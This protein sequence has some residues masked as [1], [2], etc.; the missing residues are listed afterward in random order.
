MKEIIITIVYSSLTNVVPSTLSILV[1]LAGAFWIFKVREKTAAEGKIFEL[2]RE[3]ANLLQSKKIIGPIEG[4]SYAYIDKGLHKS[5]EK[6][7]D[8]AIKKM[9]RKYLYFC[10]EEPSEDEEREAANIVVAIATERLHSLVPPKVKWSGQ[11]SFYNPYGEDIEIKDNYFPF[12]TKQYRQWIERFSDIYNDLWAI[13]NSRNSFLNN[14]LKGHKDNQVGIDK[15]FVNGWLDKIGSRIKDI[16]PIHAKLLTQIQ[17][18][19]TQVDLPRLG[20]DLGLLTLY[21]LLLLLSGFFAPKLIY[22]AELMSA[23]NIL[24]L[25]VAT[26][27]SYMLIGIR[28]IS[29]VQPVSEKKP[30]RKIFIPKLFNELDYMKK[31][32]MRY[33]PHVINNILSLDPDLKLS[34]KL[35]KTLSDLVEKIEVFNE[36]ASILYGKVEEIIEPIK[37]EFL[38]SKKNQ[39][40]F[41]I[42]IFEL[43]NE[44]YDLKDIKS[45]ILKEEYNFSFKYEEIHSLRDIFT[46]NLSELDRQKRLKLC[47]KLECLR[48]AIQS[49]PSYKSTIL[50]L[51]DLQKNREI[52]LSQV[53]KSYN[54]ALQRTNR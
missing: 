5:D 3:I 2:G 37:S 27:L 14:F 40:G 38:T 29:A 39:G 31:Q 48:G 46:I 12:G 25:A 1:P 9:L 4:I 11:G 16:H 53:E 43:A 36:F 44:E 41:S 21:G 19:D 6:N 22:L 32:C 13:T 15:D 50:A 34:N 45:R 18:I 42:T 26:T 47:E 10:G 8:K 49:L 33:K 24:S 17:I 54:K 30:L 35:K 7:R 28:I 52:A 20:K 51:N 23:R